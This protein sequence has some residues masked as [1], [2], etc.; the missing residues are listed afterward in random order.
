MKNRIFQVPYQV[1]PGF[2]FEVS[3]STD[4]S[5]IRYVPIAFF[6]HEI[7][8][9]RLWERIGAGEGNR[10]LVCSLGSYRSTIELHPRI[11]R[12]AKAG[13]AGYSSLPERSDG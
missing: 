2:F 7:V 13:G 5:K 3:L 11:V 9:D 10:T 1:Y 6:A 8:E 12:S 4:R